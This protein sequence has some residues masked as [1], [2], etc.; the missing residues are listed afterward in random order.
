[1][2]KPMNISIVNQPHINTAV[3]AIV[4]RTGAL[5]EHNPLTAFNTKTIPTQ[6]VTNSPNAMKYNRD[7]CVFVLGAPRTHDIQHTKHAMPP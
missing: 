5:S 2:I 1:M 4:N 6:F 7:H 3:A